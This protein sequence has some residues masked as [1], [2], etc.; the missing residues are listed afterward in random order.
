M[1]KFRLICGDD[2]PE[3]PNCVWSLQGLEI[4]RVKIPMPHPTTLEPM[5]GVKIMANWGMISRNQG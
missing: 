2:V 5:E 4:F 3:H 1:D